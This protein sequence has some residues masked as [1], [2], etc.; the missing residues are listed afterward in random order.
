MRPRL[1]AGAAAAI[2][3]VSAWSCFEP[4]VAERIEIRFLP[5]GA[6]TIGV[7]LRLEDPERYK[8]NARVRARL[9]EAQRGVLEDR[10]AWARRLAALDAERE[11]SRT[12]RRKGRLERSTR[13]ARL[14]DPGSIARF[15]SDTNVRADFAK[16][17]GWAEFSLVP[18]GDG[19][20]TRDQ[21]RKVAERMAEWN[22]SVAT[23]LAAVRDLWAHLDRRPERAMPCLGRL[24]REQLADDLRESLPE[25][26]EGEAELVA[27]VD[28]AMGSITAVFGVEDDDAWTLDEL[29]RLV[30][31]PFPAPVRIVVP[32]KVLE[33]E[34]F[35]GPVGAPLEIPGFSLWTA[36]ASLEG[37]WVSPDPLVALF[38][39][40]QSNRGKA[41]DLPAFVAA[42]RRAG[43]APDA[44]EVS[45]A[46]AS[47]LRPAPV[48]RVRW[49]TVEWS[50]P[51]V[52]DP[53]EEPQGR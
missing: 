39:H 1:R 51:A 43:S 2:V 11:R 26:E 8:D 41:F 29:S 5:D 38:H 50:E 15:F 30:F 34:G 37:R 13:G 3:A 52:E 36:F 7:D 40:D 33:R 27:R 24:F 44:E 12:D 32:G 45:A 28:D 31:D 20:A 10:D 4:P 17:D 18:S 16:G 14:D 25:L 53:F 9:E 35:S 47:R 23:Y 46:V 21:R 49:S 19:P 42:P 48:Y 22:A 6:A